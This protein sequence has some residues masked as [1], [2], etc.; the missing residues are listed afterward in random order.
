VG[1]KGKG[2]GRLKMGGKGRG[3]EGGR[4]SKDDNGDTIVSFC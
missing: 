3:G 1:G 2:G 4:R